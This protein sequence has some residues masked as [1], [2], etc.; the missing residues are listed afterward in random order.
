MISNWQELYE[1]LFNYSLSSIRKVGQLPL[2]LVNRELSSQL[3]RSCSSPAA[4]YLEAVE[5]SSRK[6]FIY[7]LKICRKEIKESIHWSKMIDEL[8]R[9]R[10]N[11][12]AEIAE[13]SELLKII[14]KSVVTL[15]KNDK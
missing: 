11:L 2:S 4:N 1:R 3:I 5:A 10:I 15:E 9:G 12:K 13:G 8:N 14:S 6:E 7:R